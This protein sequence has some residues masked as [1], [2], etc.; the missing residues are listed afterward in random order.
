MFHNVRHNYKLIKSACCFL[1]DKKICYHLQITMVLE[2]VNFTKL[3]E[4]TINVTMVGI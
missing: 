1:I 3:I 4:E 2:A